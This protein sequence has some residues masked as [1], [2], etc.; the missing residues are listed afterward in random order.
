M[1][2]RYTT[3]VPA[4]QKENANN[5]CAQVV[6]GGENT[7]TVP[8]VPETADMLEENISHY[9]FSWNMQEPTLRKLRDNKDAKGQPLIAKLQQEFNS[10]IYPAAAWTPDEVLKNEGLKRF[11]RDIL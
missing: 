8:L 2:T 4:S 7:V 5:L 10:R 3:I 9:W 1:A 11:Q 6:E